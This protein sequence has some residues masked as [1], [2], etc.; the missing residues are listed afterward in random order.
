M[1]LTATKVRNAKPT[2]KTQKL[3]DGEGLYLEITPKGRKYWRLKYRFNGKEKRISF[4][5]YPQVDLKE[6]RLKKSEAKLSIA[7]N[8]DPSETRRY[9]KNKKSESLQNTFK[10]VGEEWYGRQEP[11]WSE[12]YK[13]KIYRRLTQDVY[14][15]IGDKPINSITPK[16]VY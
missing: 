16:E 15:W 8:I 9:E 12:N 11:K 10:S 3:F 6:A 2:E 14:P 1:K 7:K 13:V 5:V 4:G